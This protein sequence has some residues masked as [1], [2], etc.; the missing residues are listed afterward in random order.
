[1]QQSTGHVQERQ[2]GVRCVNSF[3]SIFVNDVRVCA[4]RCFM[5]ANQLNIKSSLPYKVARKA[6]H[7]TLYGGMRLHCSMKVVLLP[8]IVHGR[9]CHYPL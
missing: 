8:Y 4:C 6:L 9:V 2:I 1:M 7:I 5:V 3:L